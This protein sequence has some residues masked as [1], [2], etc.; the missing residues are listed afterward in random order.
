MAQRLSISFG[1]GREPRV[2]GQSPAS[3]PLLSGSL[4]LTLPLLLPLLLRSVSLCQIKKIL[5][6]IKPQDASESE[7]HTSALWASGPSLLGR[8]E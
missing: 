2:V 8:S 6:N 7:L 4:L 3:G 1:S 5:K